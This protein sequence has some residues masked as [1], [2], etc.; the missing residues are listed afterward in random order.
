M[1]VR[2]SIGSVVAIIVS[3]TACAPVHPIPSNEDTDYQ[4]ISVTPVLVTQLQH[5]QFDKYHITDIIPAH[6]EEYSYKLGAGDIVDI[7]LLSPSMAE[8]PTAYDPRISEFQ[9][10]DNLAIYDD[11]TITLPY[12]GRV[13][14]AGKTPPEAQKFVEDTL[15]QYLVSLHVILTVTQYKSHQV[16][17]TGAVT[18]PGI[19][20]LRQTP[21]YLLEAVNSAGGLQD[22]ADIANATLTHK[23]GT[24]EKVDIFAL[25][26]NGSASQNRILIDGDTV[27]IPVN[28][29]NKIFV[30][31]EVNR[32][33]Q[34]FI[35]SG[36][37][38]VME[39]LNNAA[40]PVLG[41]ASYEN[42]YIIRGI[43]GERP[44]L[45]TPLLESGVYAPES[46]P[47]FLYTKIYHMDGSTSIG[48]ALA[49][50]FPLQPNDVVYVSSSGITNWNRFISQL[51]PGNLIGAAGTASSIG[52]QR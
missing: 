8:T 48:L 13:M 50:Q 25:L 16:Q 1:W 15:L 26:N 18:K 51:L 34:Q 41:T 43:I 40:G 24:I 33:S 52:A 36:S 39:A 30:L 12:V 7:T 10:Y 4:V 6:N 49:A 23:N 38:S 31:G 35:K 45:P 9:E 3:L 2:A 5:E 44:R 32:P 17:I 21:L 42:I 37:M 28:Y 19:L 22:N 46:M 29:G 47:P 11:G 27:N 14:I 20:Y